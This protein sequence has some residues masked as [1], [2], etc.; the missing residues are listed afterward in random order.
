[1]SSR[2]QTASGPDR[3]ELCFTLLNHWSYTGIGWNLGLESCAQSIADSL[4]MADYEPSVKTGINLDAYTYELVAEWYP[5]LVRRLRRYLADGRVEIVGGTFGQPMGSMVSGESNLRQ[6]AVGQ[7]TIRRV[8]GRP[9]AVFLE[10]EEMSHPQIPQLLALTGYRYGSLAQ[11]DTWGRHGAPNVEEPVVWWEGVDGTRV[12][13]VPMNPLVFHPPMVTHDI[14]WLWTDAGRAALRRMAGRRVPLALKWTEFGWEKL[15]GKAIN[16]F[17]PALFRELSEKFR[18][19]YVTVE[20]YLDRQAAA[21][22]ATVPALRLR[23]DDFNKLLPWGIGGDQVRRFGR[24]VEATLLAAERFEAAAHALGLGIDDAGVLAEAWRNLLAAQ[25]HDVSLCEYT[26]HQGAA[27]P[28]DPVLDAHFQ[29]WGS[30]GY[31]LMDDAM[32]AGR[33]VLHRSLRALA[34]RIGA[35]PGGRAV[36]AFN[37]CGFARAALVTTG[38]LQLEDIPCTSVVVRNAAGEA[39]PSQLVASERSKDGRLVCAE[40]AFAASALPSVGYETF[41]LEPAQ[42]E[43]TAAV[44]D[45]RIDPA[46]GVLENRFVR[47]TLDPISGAIRSLVDRRT[48]R[49]CLGGAGRPF[50]TLTGEAN[51]SSPLARPPNT[52]VAPYDTAMTQAQVAWL[53]S[54]PLRAR[55]RAVHPETR[56]LRFEITISLTTE[57]A[58]VEV[59][60]RVFPD[61]PPKVGEA[62]INGWQFP[63]EITEGYWLELVP[64]FNVATVLRDYPFGAEPAAK[65]AFTSLTWLDLLAADDSGLLVVHSGTQYFKRRGDGS[66]ANL[67]V[68][69][70]ESHFT[71]E[72]GWPRTCS[73]RYLLRPHGPGLTL[74][75]RVKAAAAFDLKPR[76]VVLP[77][78]VGPASPRASLV[79]VEGPGAVL[80]AFRRSADD[81]RCEVRVVEG[82][83]APGEARLA[84]TMPLAL[85]Q[86]T[87][88]L[89][90]SLAGP[91]P[92][93]AAVAL[94]PW[95][96]KTFKLHS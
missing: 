67:V 94:R 32:A 42:D 41:S 83:G 60:V 14:D 53:E 51:G 30:Y 47:V 54:G 31:R 5:H 37:P 76:C 11:C 26:R 29:T 80:S 33:K 59:G 27:P 86:A 63:L 79:A 44:T 36:V 9:V 75:E 24:E 95:E 91:A 81:G 35:R 68:R 7:Q 16:K 55:V 84:T 52:P 48:G 38:P 49:E 12:L 90:E 2:P 8:L 73:Y 39:V 65:P 28:A 62:K 96:I 21:G 45:L 1:M 25:S 22:V 50:P 66:F 23:A 89:G 71:G 92:V 64:G 57:S 18:V 10:E 15:T 74:V 34:G 3:P 69:E 43:G 77:P 4:D 85:R 13:A 87:D 93:T 46:A 78:P 88:A 82:E 58:D 72:F 70:W 6:L 40:V 17:D 56:G 19:E 61:L 20:Q